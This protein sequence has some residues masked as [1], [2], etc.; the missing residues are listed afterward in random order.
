MYQSFIILLSIATLFTLINIR[1]LK[2]PLTIGLM[3][4]GILL[5]GLLLVVKFISPE[6]FSEIPD[7][8]KDIDFEKFLMN[9][10][11][12]FLL[13]AGAMHID[14]KELRK[15]RASV[16]T[17]SILGTIIS[18][19]IIGYLLYF[20]FGLLGLNL[21]LLHCLLFGALISPTD[22]IAVLGIFNKY[23]VRKDISV[24]IEGESLFNDGVGI[25]LFLTFLS[26]IDGN[27]NGFSLTQTS[28]LFFRQII[29]GSFFGLL[30]GWLSIQF[31][32]QL[33][34]DSDSSIMTT[35][36]I[37]TGGYS[38]AIM[39]EVSGPL[40]MV[41]SGL[42]V[43]NWIHTHSKQTTQTVIKSFWKVI[44]TIFNSSLFV[45]MGMAVLLISPAQINLIAA[46]ITILVVLIG[47]FISVAIP[48]TVLEK[49]VKKFP[50]INIKM[51]TI[52]TWSGLRGALAFALALSIDDPQLGPFFIFLTYCV[53]AFSIIV[54]G[55]TIPKVIK[56]MK[57]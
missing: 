17:F 52:M 41:F 28:I 11:L 29:G 5:S 48:Y 46:L 2:L 10:I 50:W 16:Y 45:L 30:I 7:I 15:E 26:L 47:R 3:I 9:G 1:F 23:K 51:V 54:Q 35:L 25:V 8:V 40:T 4:L 36:L 57:I 32:K 13:F 12:S 34:H 27:S 18:T 38:L 19:F 49:K 22:P 20:V 44:D 14:I 24:K 43:G 56:A 37:A 6:L 53:V 55:L 42:I 21:P 39:L 33:K 31:L